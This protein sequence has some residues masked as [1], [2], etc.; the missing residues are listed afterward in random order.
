VAGPDVVCVV[1]AVD[2]RSGRDGSLS[3]ADIE[4]RDDADE[5]RKPGPAGSD[6]AADNLEQGFLLLTEEERLVSIWKK[7]GFSDREIAKHLSRPASAV[8]EVHRRAAS[9]IHQALD[10]KCG[11][12]TS[13]DDLPLNCPVCGVRLAFRGC[14]NGCREYTC[15][16]HGGFQIERDGR[17]RRTA[18]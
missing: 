6:I 11:T 1:A 14:M 4:R 15:A 7:A 8:R 2:P 16:E 18:G 12:D 5:A 13:D 10:V 3:R 9:K 17:F